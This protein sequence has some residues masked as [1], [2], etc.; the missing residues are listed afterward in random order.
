MICLE[1]KGKVIDNEVKFK[2][3][4]IQ[5]KKEY[6]KKELETLIDTELEYYELT[7]D[8]DECTLKCSN[9]EDFKSKVLEFEPS[10][11]MEDVKPKK[12]LPDYISV[13]SAEEV[14]KYATE[15]E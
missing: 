6:L 5:C 3:L 2:P 11:M 10:G 7:I 12:K 13:P 15:N 4:K 8:K 1:L 9:G 14:I